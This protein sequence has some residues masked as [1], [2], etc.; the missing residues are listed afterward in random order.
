MEEPLTVLSIGELVSLF[1]L[2][3][4]FETYVSDGQVGRIDEPCFVLLN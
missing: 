3:F 1:S 2:T 4:E